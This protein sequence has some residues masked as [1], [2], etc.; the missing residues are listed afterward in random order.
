[1]KKLSI[2]ITMLLAA[3]LTAC[4]EDFNEG[5]ASPQSYGQE[6]AAGKITFAATGVDPI[7]LGN[8]SEESVVV[9]VFTAPVVQEETTFSYKMKLDNKVTLDVNSEG[10]VTTENLQDAVGQIYGIRP[11]ERTMKAVL[12]AYVTSGK[13]VYAVPAEEFELKVTP[14]APEIE[15]AYYINGSLTWEQ[16]VAF[17]NTSGDPYANSVFTTTVPAVITDNTGAEDAYFLIKSNSGKSLGVADAD[18]DALEGNLVLSEAAKPIKI[19]GGDYKSVKISINMMEGTYKI[20]KI[21][22][23]PYLW[24]PG[25]HQGWAPSQAPTLFNPEGNKAH[26]G[27]SELNGGFK[28]TAQPYWP[29]NSNGGVD[30]GYDYF[31]SKEGIAND[32]GNL[33]LPQGIYYMMVNLDDKYVSATEITSMDIIGT[34]VGGWENG[35]ELTYDATEKCWTLN[36]EMTAGDFKLRVNSTWDPNISFGGTLD[37]PTPFSNDNIVMDASGNY[38]IKFYLS[39]RLVLI[40]E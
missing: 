35:K 7:N 16:N 19:S 34:A 8:V 13:S 32:G 18:N 25:N 6:E 36:T 4:N 20:E 33:S 9:A 1:M 31:T 15:S 39:S 29:N 3:S 2:Y 30:Y 12:I 37:A 22:D 10:Y 27:M 26:W 11:V 5:V 40:K 17:S 38:T 28:F 23:A 21:T 14:K 24:I